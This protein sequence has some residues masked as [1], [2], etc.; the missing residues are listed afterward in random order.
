MQET[1]LIMNEDYI[2]GMAEYFEKQGKQLQNMA[3][4]YV[5]AIKRITEE[6]I[7]KGETSETLK[8]FLEYAEKLNRVIELTAKEVRDS[9]VNYQ[10]EIDAQD[11]YLY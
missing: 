7:V 6:G 5:A 2:Y 10:E 11:Q 4:S 9:V 1:E 8:I 3:D